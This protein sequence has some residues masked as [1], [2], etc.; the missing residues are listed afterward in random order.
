MK[1]DASDFGSSMMTSCGYEHC[2]RISVTEYQLG[3]THHK[4]GGRSD[5]LYGHETKRENLSSTL[6]EVKWMLKQYMLVLL[7]HQPLPKSTWKH[8]CQFIADYKANVPA[9][10][11]CV[12]QPGCS[13]QWRHSARAG[14]RAEAEP[15]G[16]GRIDTRY[17]WA[18]HVRDLEL[19]SKQDVQTG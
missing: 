14:M 1:E 18:F 15:K 8:H 11:G 19:D 9:A 16:M 12:L 7:L 3:Y 5:L 13:H 10:A 2:H 6:T 17:Q 4:C